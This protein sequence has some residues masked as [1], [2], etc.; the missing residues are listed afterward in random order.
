MMSDIVRQ[1]RATIETMD[2]LPHIDHLDWDDWNRNH[3]AKHAVTSE[4]AERAVAGDPI[5]RTS[6]K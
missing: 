3:I 6:Y 2:H 5:Y 4:E 1:H